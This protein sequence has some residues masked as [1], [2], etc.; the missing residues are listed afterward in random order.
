M[1]VFLALE[2]LTEV[3][4]TQRRAVASSAQVDV[5]LAQVLSQQIVHN[6]LQLSFKI[7]RRRNVYALLMGLNKEIFVNTAYMAAKH[8]VI[9]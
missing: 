6:A 7:L 5:L 8:A 4:Q 2:A 1:T 9:I 3:F